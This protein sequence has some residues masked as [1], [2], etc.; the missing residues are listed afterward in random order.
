MQSPGASEYFCICLTLGSASF[1]EQNVAILDHIVLALGHN[2]TLGLDASF[3]TL[4]PQYTVVI[5]N[6]LNEGLFEITMNDT[7]SLGRLCAVT[8][9]PLPNL[10]R[11]GCKEAAKVESLAHS[12]DDLGQRGLG[13]EILALLSS[14]FLGHGTETLFKGNGDRDDW[15]TLCILLDP[16]SD[17]GKVLVLLADVVLLAEVDE[18]DNG[19]SG[20]EEERIDDLDLQLISG[21]VC[22]LKE[23]Q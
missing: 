4:L 8:Y 12:G 16:L 20:K 15:I 19:L 18:E 11:T 3:V 7:S 14:L 1:D 2:L 21:L 23:K 9:C 17:L 5:H 6:C 13:A 22:R 10:V